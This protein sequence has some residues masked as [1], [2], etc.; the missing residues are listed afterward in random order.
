MIWEWEGLDGEWL[1]VLPFWE[2]NSLG[3]LKPLQFSKKFFER[4]VRKYSEDGGDEGNFLKISMTVGEI[5]KMGV[6]PP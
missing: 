2:A 3:M 4:D 5:K 1:G 6:T